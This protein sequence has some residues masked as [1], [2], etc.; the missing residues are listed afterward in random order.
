MSEKIL[1]I[2]AIQLD[3]TPVFYHNI[4]LLSESGALI[5]KMQVTVDE[6]Q[7]KF[8]EISKV[9]WDAKLKNHKG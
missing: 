7:E 1:S 2:Y 5:D 4:L 9:W 8:N 6:S 3:T